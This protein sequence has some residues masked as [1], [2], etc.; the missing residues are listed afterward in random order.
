MLHG[1]CIDTYVQ[2]LSRHLPATIRDALLMAV[3]ILAAV[4]FTLT[5]VGRAR[6]LIQ[7]GDPLL[8][9]GEQNVIF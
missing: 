7:E 8:L 6:G 1:W 4:D 5:R 2:G 3:F 9:V